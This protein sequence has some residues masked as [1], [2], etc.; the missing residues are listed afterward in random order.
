MC[1]KIIIFLIVLFPSLSFASDWTSKD[2]KYQVAYTTLH[3][4][5][6]LQTLQIADNPDRYYEKNKVIGNHPTR[7][8]VNTYFATTLLLHT[9]VS[10]LLP[11]KYRRV[12][13]VVTIGIEGNV[14]VN[15]YNIG[16]RFK[17]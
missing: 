4:A 14:A 10:Y 5:D 11:P 1:L 13:Q 15:N 9:G 7:G 8:R 16:L 6:W 17:F 2:T 3:V 12:W